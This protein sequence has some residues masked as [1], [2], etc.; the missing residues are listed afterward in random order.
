[1]ESIGLKNR[2]IYLFILL[3][4]FPTRV[5]FRNERKTDHYGIGRRGVNAKPEQEDLPLDREEDCEARV[6][7]HHLSQNA[8]I[9]GSL[10]N[11]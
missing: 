2:L 4:R 8:E 7:S 3:T 11:C 6:C 1:M 10:A 5:S 9:D